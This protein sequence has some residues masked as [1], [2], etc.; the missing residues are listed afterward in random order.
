MAQNLNAAAT[1]QLWHG[2]PAGRQRGEFLLPP[3]VTKVA[4][5]SEFGAAGVHR[6]DRV[7]LASDFNAALLFACGHRVPAV[8]LV[9]AQGGLEP[10]PDCTAPG[11][12]FQC[13][14][15]RVLRVIKLWP[16]LIADARAVLL[17]SERTAPPVGRRLLLSRPTQI[18]R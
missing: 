4:S 6:R 3:S 18:S 15:A 11:L 8:Y 14:M 13:E 12:S 17:S 2:G 10:D 5:C 9:E 16:S 7:Y 1:R